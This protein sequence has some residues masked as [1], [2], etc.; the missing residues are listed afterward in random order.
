MHCQHCGAPLPSGAITCLNCGAR[1]ARTTGRNRKTG[2]LLAAL[3]AAG[4][5][6]IVFIGL[7]LPEMFTEPAPQPQPQPQQQ[8]APIISSDA[9][10]PTDVRGE[11]DGIY[12]VD[13][14][15][16]AFREPYTQIKGDGTDT[17]TVM[18]YMVGADLESNSGCATADLEEMLAAEF[19]E[20]VRVVVQTGGCSY[21][22]NGTMSDG[23]TERWL[24]QDG[25]VL[26]LDNLGTQPM[27]QDE[28]VTDFITFSAEQYPA[29]RYALIFWDHGGGSVY[30]FGSD[31]MFPNDVLYLPDIRDA[32]ENAGVQF[33]FIGFD[34][35]L[36]G[37]LETAYMLE[38]YADYL[39][40]SEELEPGEGW[41]YTDWLTLLEQNPSLDTVSLG[42]HIVDD[43][44]NANDPASTLS[45]VSLREIPYVYE[46]LNAYMSAANAVL[47]RP[48]FQKI[49][50]ARSNTKAFDN[51][52]LD[53]VDLIDF[54]D[55][56]G[57]ENSDDLR[58]A[59]QSAVKYRNDCTVDGTH[60]LSVYFPYTDLKTY[61]AAK[62][63]FN[64]FGFGGASFTF[65]DNFVNMLANGQMSDPGSS[66]S[67]YLTGVTAAPIDYS[68]YDWYN[69]DITA[70]GGAVSIDTLTITQSGDNW[71]LPLSD[72]QWENIS[73][74]E[75]QVLYDDG[76]GYID[77][78]SDQV[79]E[80]DDDDNL[81][82]TFDN[83]W[84][85]L[86]GMCVP[87]Y[88]EST[89]SSGDDIVFT[90]YVPAMLNKE[91]NIDIILK[92][93]TANSDGYI[94]GYRYTL[95][96]SPTGEG[97][98]VGKGLLQFM[99][100]DTVRIICDYYTYDGN[101]E[102]TYALGD[103]IAIGAQLP[104]VSYEDIGPNPVI[105]SFMITDLYQ[106]QS[107]TEPVQM[108]SW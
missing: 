83:Y 66:L 35:C 75:L 10:Q 2:C 76:A 57:L 7:M 94:A 16:V 80:T 33:D 54:V 26:H 43:F 24:L 91:T 89:V 106:S 108:G 3:I 42:V 59:V 44:I 56:V 20:N 79:F 58:D 19:G 12:G 72:A 84:V 61:S 90:G 105:V 31:E 88:A 49:S 104:V 55:I 13:I 98:T 92:W 40:A 107:W 73:A 39:I 78:G 69:P 97:G 45:V 62:R 51:G 11:G 71:I 81:L 29:N 64:E 82:I 70:E 28:A 87:Y 53:M 22:Q 65:Y 96:N 4:V 30:G 34:A 23:E 37:S 32:L 41:Y 101:Y 21:W 38:P 27:L 46:Q 1:V 15:D 36:M 93:D 6:L 85:A 60:G 100:E 50:S 52:E 95:G 74:I 14:T 17:V 77:Y 102:Q 9:H 8:S 25:G 5:L 18:V 103:S 86:D 47:V 99:P 63:F 68:Q 48:E 67:D